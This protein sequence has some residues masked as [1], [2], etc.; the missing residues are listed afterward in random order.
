MDE[1]LEKI[2]NADLFATIGFRTGPGRSEFTLCCG[3]DSYFDGYFNDSVWEDPEAQDAWVEMWRYTAERYKDNPNVVGYKLMVEPNAEAIFFDAY[4]PDEFYPDQA[5]TLYDWNQFFPRIVGG[6]RAVDSQ[7]PLLVGG[8]GFSAIRWL[9]HLEPIDDPYV[10]YVAHQYTPFDEYTHQPPDGRNSYPGAID[11]DYDGRPDE[12]NREWLEDLLTPLDQYAANTGAPI[13]VDEF[14]VNRWVPGAAA[15]MDDLMD[16]FEQRG[17]NHSLWEWQ[18]SWPDFRQDVHDMDYR[19][20][21]DPDS[22]SETESDLLEAITKYWGRNTVRPSNV[23][24]T[25]EE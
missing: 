13:A 16:L 17:I 12:F 22:R 7:T 2:A 23:P 11:L 10:V 21:T 15:Y 18:T 3:G 24:W 8:M 4:E 19:L 14:G 6:I 25:A 9:P 20:G 1:L 5:G